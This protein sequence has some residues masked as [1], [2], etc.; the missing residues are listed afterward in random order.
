MSVGIAAS[1]RSLQHLAGLL[2]AASECD[3]MPNFLNVLSVIDTVEELHEGKLV[4][5]PK[6]ISNLLCRLQAQ[7]VIQQHAD[8]EVGRL[9]HGESAQ[10]VKKH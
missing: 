1:G 4:V 6:E 5:G 7:S 9:P 8:G 3:V 2:L 10:K